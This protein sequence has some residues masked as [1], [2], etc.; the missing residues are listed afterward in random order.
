[1]SNVT[2]PRQLTA[3]SREN[4]AE[5]RPAGSA[6]SAHDAN[7]GILML[8]D[9]ALIIVAMRNVVLFPGM[10][11]PLTI[12]RPQS[13]AAA[14]QAVKMERPIGILL[15]RDPEVQ[16]PGPDDLC[17]TGTLANILRY[18]TLPDDSHVIVC[19]GQQR[20]RVGEFLADYPFPVAR[21]VRVD[22]PEAA[23]T[24]VEAR[25][26]QLRQRA[27]EVLQLLPQASDEMSNV[28]RSVSSP[29][30]LA[31]L[32]AGLIEI[33][34]DERQAVL[35]AVDLVLRLDLV[36]GYLVKRLEVL[37]IS[38]QI[39]ER[40]KASI[41]E[42]QR[43]FLLRE[44]LKAI[45]KELGEGDS[46]SSAEIAELRRSIAAAQ[47]PEEVERQASKE[48]KRLEHMSDASAEYSMV[49]AYLDWLLELPWK[50]PEP[51]RIDIAEAR[52]SL[53]ADHFGLDQVKKRIVEFLAVRKLK[54]EGHGPILC[55]VGPPGV[56]KTSLGQ[57]IARALGRK[58]VRASLGG[59]HDEAEIRGHRRTYIGA[60]PG[61]IIQAIAKAGS[62]GCV[63]M[64][65]EI[66]KLASGVHGDPSAALLEVLDPEQNFSFRDNYLA[67]P[68]DLSRVLFIT[69]ANVLDNIPGPLRDRMEIITLP[70]Y[71]QEEKR[72][73]ARRYLVARQVEQNGL[74]AAQF[75]ISDA[76]LM[77]IIRDY[78]REAG[79][80][81]LERQIGAVCRRAAVSIAEG[82]VSS[83]KIDAGDLAAIL[84]PI[85]YENEVALRSGQPGV[86]TGLAWTPVGGD[87]LFIE[88][89]RMAG[90]GRLIL[91]GQ[92]GEVMKESA[93]AALTLL[94]TRAA[95][96][97]IDAAEFEKTSVHVHVPAGAIPKDGP[98][99]GVAMFIALASLFCDRTVRNDTAMTGEISL[100]GLV[101]PVGGIKEKV[102]AAMRAGIRRVM[103]PARN[104]RDLDEVPAE[105]RERLEFVFLDNVDDAENQSMELRGEPRT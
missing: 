83:L 97:G 59:V 76:A 32:I 104:R 4:E 26:I 85:Q 11:L 92:L 22:E 63:L 91:T 90:D 43:E 80:R 74:T 42:H 14:Q 33:K 6:A 55:F 52:N 87:I 86:A 9:D 34:T 105:A 44:Q 53:D 70:G 24:E 100:R 78:T 28:V 21:V 73:I 51:D 47:M 98:S 29:G 94:K 75:E 101:L 23:D 68:Y 16:A 39:D 60:L 65:D 81:T 49:R 31:D 13:L 40:T 30:A 62:R 10:I 57:S 82:A 102:L 7:G 1:M 89:S 2:M 64:L 99:A 8:P 84:G 66:D 37:K 5:A 12:G 56:G 45:Q 19:Q 25:T 54:P 35:E 41:D 71:T 48:L 18:V 46:G 69:T 20:F 79:V 61:N 50:A 3:A 103:L 88:A 96:L 17:R 27:L 93:Q 95:R 77:A 72:E 36:L 38:R 58:F 15:Q 67:L